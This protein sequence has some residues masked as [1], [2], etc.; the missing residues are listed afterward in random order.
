MPRFLGLFSRK[1][2][3]AGPPP[4]P[5]TPSDDH[6]NV[7]ISP[8]VSNSTGHD[9]SLRTSFSRSHRHADSTRSAHAPATP[10]QA[11]RSSVYPS[12]TSSPSAASTASSS[13][14][15]LPFSRKRQPPAAAASTTSVNT[16]ASQTVAQ[17]DCHSAPRPP[18]ADRERTST[19]SDGELTDSRRLRPPP[20]KS[21]I[22]AAYADPQGALST[23]SLPN[24]APQPFS[25]PDSGMPSPPSDCPQPI[26]APPPVSPPRKSFFSW[27][28]SPSPAPVA[29][30][31]SKSTPPSQP[32]Q[33]PKADS[34]VEVS[35][36][37][38]NLK[39]FRHVG[40]SSPLDSQASLSVPSPS[41]LP[42]PRGTS[43]GDPSQRIS[44]A[45][46]REAQ[47]RRSS[48]V[49]SPVPSL[50]SSSPLGTPPTPQEPGGRASPRLGPL[51][52]SISHETNNRGLDFDSD[53][54]TSSSEEDSDGESDRERTLTQRDRWKGKTKAK[55]EM[56][57]GILTSE[58]MDMPSRSQSSVGQHP[59]RQR[60]SMSTS[61]ATPSAAAKK[62]SI[63]VNANDPS[64][65]ALLFLHECCVVDYVAPD[66][67]RNSRHVREPSVYS[68]LGASTTSSFS[69]NS[70]LRQMP[71]SDSEEEE[72]DAPLATL[73]PPR[74]PGSALSSGSGSS[75]PGSSRNR[76]NSNIPLAR[77]KP[78][79][80]ISEI[81][82]A[83]SSLVEEK[84][85]TQGKTLLAT[86]AN[87]SPPAMTSGMTECQFRPN[88][89]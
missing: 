49:D 37:S 76:S 50:R 8:T 65:G 70:A 62:A 82:S 74:R 32:V 55:S 56:G 4:Q 53:A 48:M 14:L 25:L 68:N 9:R 69:P 1:S 67:T 66:Y 84:G 71:S 80:D 35:N 34:G 63:L 31:K 43:V 86:S 58:N 6:S 39:S 33:D 5:S 24:D 46:F 51:K 20:S 85:F 83:K 28:R 89:D 3:N 23:R 59:V 36:S 27:G 61:A 40:P 73:V 16:A 57:H 15:R 13:K 88:L 45:A 29:K 17:R 77:G 72:E 79:I 21:A 38:F 78:L 60:A 22:F 52:S 42:R 30:T 2:K 75:L 87:T 54:D 47:A 11:D 64:A 12:I 41:P 19:A 26:Q 7:S 44:V 18:F 81:L 10:A